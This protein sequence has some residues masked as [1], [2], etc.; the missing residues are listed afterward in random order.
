MGIRLDELRFRPGLPHFD[1]VSL[2]KVRLQIRQSAEK[3]YPWEFSGPAF[4]IGRDPACELAMQGDGCQSVSWSH[5]RVELTAQ[6][7]FVSDLGSSNGTY[8]NGRRIAARTPLHL[9]DLIELGRTGPKL[10]VAELELDGA[11]VVAADSSPQATAF[12]ALPVAPGPRITPAASAKGKAPPGAVVPV[13]AESHSGGTTRILLAKLQS[14]QR[15]S[16]FLVGASLF[17]IG[18]VVAL[19]LFVILPII[20]LWKSKARD[21]PSPPPAP[22]PVALTPAEVYKQLIHSTA[23]VVVIMDERT[24]FASLGSGSLVDRQRRLVLTNHHVVRDKDI[25][26]VFFPQFQDGRAIEQK[27]YYIERRD[28][29]GITGRV[30]ARDIKRDL[31]L[32]ELERVPDDVPQLKLAEASAEEGHSVFSI[33][34]PGKMEDAMWQYTTGTVRQVHLYRWG[35]N[36]G[37]QREAWVV[38]TQSPVN[39]GDS[40][41]PVVNDQC[42]LVAVVAGGAGDANLRNWFIDRREVEALLNGH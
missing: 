15:R 7:A 42:E 23:W 19:V 32:I 31:A 28:T 22:A 37:L 38:E 6:G 18:A 25:A 20:V 36:D 4:R 5:A 41:G 21:N 40:G 30:V 34:N 35:Y 27:K 33:G 17:G 3:S 11:V 1:E 8:V 9:E 39:H 24:G 14:S 16:M 29:L 13:A 2:M 10:Q 26:H 12:E